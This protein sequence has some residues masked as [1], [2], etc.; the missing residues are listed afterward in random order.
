MAVPG[1]SRGQPSQ[2]APGVSE[3]LPQLQSR[4]QH[5]G[6]E[7]TDWEPR[8]QG[9][10]RDPP[11][12]APPHPHP[13]RYMH[14]PSPSC[15]WALPPGTSLGQKQFPLDGSMAPRMPTESGPCPHPSSPHH[16]RSW[17]S[18]A[19]K[20][21]NK[22]TEPTTGTSISTTHTSG[23]TRAHT[24]DLLRHHHR[25]PQRHTH[26]IHTLQYTTHTTY[27]LPTYHTLTT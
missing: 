1:S 20:V 22:Q 13:P 18:A 2:A 11:L 19:S 17:A 25:P 3:G 21:K 23:P 12:T 9:H 6:E 8:V 7:T 4:I 14:K 15:S 10:A 24:H 16:L 26:T 27:L 5:T